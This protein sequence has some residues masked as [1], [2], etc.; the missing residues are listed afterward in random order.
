MLSEDVFHPITPNY[1]LLGKAARDRE[2]WEAKEPEMAID[3][4]TALTAE[5][6]MCSRWW[7]E[8]I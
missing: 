3:P 5:E 6:E 7:P 8:W 4:T 1:L 2:S